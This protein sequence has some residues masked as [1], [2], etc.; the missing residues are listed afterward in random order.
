M[1]VLRYRTSFLV[2]ERKLF[3]FAFDNAS[4][5]KAIALT[6]NEEEDVG[7]LNTATVKLGKSKIQAK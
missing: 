7:E 6:V 4:S 2:R 5:Q 1:K 3:D